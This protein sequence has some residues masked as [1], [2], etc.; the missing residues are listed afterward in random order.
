MSRKV[1]E[2]SDDQLL[3]R[4]KDY[5]DNPTYHPEYLQL[6]M[7]DYER[8]VTERIEL[9]GG[10]HKP[11]RTTVCPNMTNSNMISITT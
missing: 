2:I 6:L 4:M 10:N 9:H 1:N 11:P 5:L 8:R 3:K 7:K